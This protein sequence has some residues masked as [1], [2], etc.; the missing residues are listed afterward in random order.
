[1]VINNKRGY[2]KTLEAIIGLLILF[3]TI[4]YIVSSDN[5]T[6]SGETP[7]RIRL[8][9]KSVLNWAE[10]DIS[11]RDA[12]VDGDLTWVVFYAQ[13]YY[14]AP[15]GLN[16]AMSRNVPM[17]DSWFADKGDVYVDSVIIVSSVGNTSTLILYLWED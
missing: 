17:P 4:L 5:Q 13:N 7:E 10:H 8:V 9:Q 11:Y 6:D 16:L 14:A 2:L 3:G 1:M 12:I 15:L